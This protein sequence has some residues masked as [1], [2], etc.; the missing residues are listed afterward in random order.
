MR[1]PLPPL[2][3]L[4]QDGRV[5]ACGSGTAVDLVET[6]DGSV[7]TVHLPHQARVMAFSPYAGLFAV[8]GSGQLSLLKGQAPFSLLAT[9]SAPAPL[10]RLVVGEE[11]LVVGATQFQEVKSTLC[12]WRGEQMQPSFSGAGQELGTVAPFGLQLDELR[13]RVVVWGLSGTDAYSGSGEPFVRLLALSEIGV[14]TLWTGEDMPFQPEGFLLPLAEGRL[15]LYDWQRLVAVSTDIHPGQPLESYDFEELETVATSPDG[16]L[17]A[18][19]WSTWEDE[20]DIY[21]IQVA[22][23]ADSNLMAEV[24][25]EYLGRFP[26]LAVDD[27]GCATLVFSEMPNRVLTFTLDD[28]QLTERA[29]VQVRTVRGQQSLEDVLLSIEKGM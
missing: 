20:R 13:K 4:S 23:L 14:E 11:G 6:R 3:V 29:H 19:L 27:V 24:T 2:A 21:H 1:K 22:R 25:F 10:F 26:A 5:A 15:G 9:V 17:L 18:W 7:S 16:T 28:G 8:A 12:V